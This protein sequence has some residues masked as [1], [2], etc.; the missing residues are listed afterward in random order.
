MN[1]YIGD[2]HF[3]HANVIRFDHRPFLDTDEMDRTLIALWNDRVQQDDTVYILGDLCYRSVR[4]PEWYLRQLKGHKILILGNHDG[5][6]LKNSNV[7]KYL[8]GMEKML[9]ISDDNRQITLCHF[10]L[11]EWTGFHRGAWHI[12]AHIHNRTD[13]AYQYMK[14]LDRALNAGCMINYYTPVSFRELERNNKL[15]KEQNP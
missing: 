2:P 3:G 12:Y 15:F 13:G 4:E 10:P 11:A 1:L 6:L 5:P 8:E 14:N 9:R 7:M